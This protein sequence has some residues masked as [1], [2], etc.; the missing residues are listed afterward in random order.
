MV[1]DTRLSRYIS[2]LTF[3]RLHIIEFGKSLYA[4]IFPFSC[5]LHPTVNIVLAYLK[6]TVNITSSPL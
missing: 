3:P 1:V 2:N 6:I 4:D 5:F